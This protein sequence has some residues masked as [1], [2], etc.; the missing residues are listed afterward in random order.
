MN[1][2]KFELEGNDCAL[3]LKSDMSMELVLPNFDDESKV[4]FDKNQNIFIAMAISASMSDEKFKEY[5]K[6][7]L[8]TIFE[9]ADALRETEEADTI[10]AEIIE[11][12][13]IEPVSPCPACPGCNNG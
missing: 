12:T 13:D 11:E 4:D 6:T 10:D 9:T 5:I 2:T 7:K 1:K 8:D 3:I